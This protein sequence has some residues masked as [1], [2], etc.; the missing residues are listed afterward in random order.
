MTHFIDRRDPWGNRYSL[1]VVVAMAF[2]APV[3]IWAVPQIRFENQIEQWLPE[4]DTD[5]VVQKWAGQQFPVD[6][7][8]VVTWDG[9]SL[10]DPRIDQ[11]IGEL[12]GE[13]D[14]QG[15]PRGGVP[16]V[17][18]IMDP[19]DVLHD[20]QKN[21]VEVAEAARRMQGLLL[22][23]GPLRIRLTDA[24]RAVL[25]KTKRE[26]EV[27]A[28][29]K[30]GLTVNLTEPTT[31][32][33]SNLSIPTLNEDGSAGSPSAPIVLSADG[34]V[35]ENQSA[36]HDF[37]MTWDGLQFGSEAT[38]QIATWLVEYTP[39]RNDQGRLVESAFFVPGSPVALMVGISEAGR[40]D[41]VE[42]V[43]AIQLACQR[44]GIDKQ[45]LHLAG[46]IVVAASLDQQVQS[47]IWNAEKS[48][49][50]LLQ[51][52]VLLTS[53][54]IGAIAVFCLMRDVRLAAMTVFISLFTAGATMS[55]I[56][57]TGGA[58][59][60]ISVA[61]PVMIGLLTMSGGLFLVNHWKLT[62]A[63]DVCTSVSETVAISK[64]PTR[65]TCLIAAIGC[66]SL[67]SSVISPVGEYGFY[68]ALGSIF[69]LLTVAYA[70][71]SFLQMWA[72]SVSHGNHFDRVGWQFLG[73][74]LTARPA[75]QSLIMV[76]LF[77]ACGAGVFMARSSVTESSYF[78]PTAKIVTDSQYV[79]RNLSGT[80]PVDLIIRFDEQSQKSISF[81][82]R[83]ESVRRV[84]QA[85]RATNGISGCLSLA[86]FLPESEKPPEDASFIQRSKFNKRA[87]AIQQRI[88]E[89]DIPLARAFY[90]IAE[91]RQ[92]LEHAGDGKL[93]LP[94]D[95]LWR[96]TS[97]VHS[98][99]DEKYETVL[100]KLHEL[101]QDVL[102][103]QPGSHHFITGSLPIL[104]K[105]KSTVLNDLSGAVILASVLIAAVT[106]FALRN[107]AVGGLVLLAAI[108]PS[109]AVCGVSSFL[110]RPIDLATLIAVPSSLFLGAEGALHCLT[111]FRR[112][113]KFGKDR[114][115]AVI[116]ALIHC[117]PSFWQSRTIVLLGL[118]PLM[119]TEFPLLGRF[120]TTLAF[121]CG[122]SLICSVTLIPQILAGPLGAFFEPVRTKE[123]APV[124]VIQPELSTVPVEP[125]VINETPIIPEP[126]IKPLAPVAKKRRSSRRDSDAS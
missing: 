10:S 107:M 63:S 98:P 74:L 124:R 40:A 16:Y 47:E 19:R 80:I 77:G 69:A 28:R 1:W 110:G 72:G 23:T 65:I 8:V 104:A 27:A 87:T 36:N 13:S 125:V 85:I 52:S 64:N 34:K 71:P 68:A 5:R 114:R 100:V 78:P 111:C 57:V 88:Q 24:G 46:N 20:I 97:S 93:N 122:A 119:S 59:N 108:L 70:L 55:M 123:I 118:M 33:A 89:G 17:S 43:K 29:S 126:H 15:H 81:L 32:V 105:M 94:G 102:K 112:N 109:T 60:A 106:A 115:T 31:D 61:L 42:A 56:P 35:A 25:R 79:D 116:D 3:C 49:G 39:Q 30:F 58:L 76:G 26:I 120:A 75:L 44:A 117:G 99:K 83:M 9:S 7:Q 62:V 48:K 21:E 82:E 18:S 101:T 121:V 6:Q 45:S 73:Q 14:G 91:Q 11:L 38:A 53:L 103:V 66:I 50:Q 22:G 90:S 12:K 4:N 51:R 41:K 54:I 113:I 67:C 86:D 2:V 96:I 95:E 37:Q 92:D 84:Q